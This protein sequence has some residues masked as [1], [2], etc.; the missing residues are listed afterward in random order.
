MKVI[1][2][3]RVKAALADLDRACNENP[4]LKGSDQWT[5]T[6]VMEVL[7]MDKNIYNVREA[8]VLLG[9]TAETLRREV[10]KGNLKAAKVG[11]D[12][13]ISKADLE[14]YYRTRGGGDLFTDGV[15]GQ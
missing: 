8:A 10:R 15:T 14:A 1:D 4:T 5:E 11:R 2:L 12:L 6:E 3:V 9:V 7:G 13:R